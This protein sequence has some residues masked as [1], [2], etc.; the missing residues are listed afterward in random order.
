MFVCAVIDRLD[1][2]G[3]NLTDLPAA[4]FELTDLVELS[5]AGNQLTQLPHGVSR[6]VSLK[7]LVLAGNWLQHLPEQLWQL[8]GLEG[9]W[10]HGNLLQDVAQQLGSLHALRM[11]SL[12]GRQQLFQWLL[13]LMCSRKHHFPMPAV[14]SY[15]GRG[16]E[17]PSFILQGISTCV[18]WP[19]RQ[20]KNHPTL[21]LDHS[22]CCRQLP[23]QHTRFRHS[24]GTP[25]GLELVRQPDQRAAR[26]LMCVDSTDNALTARQPAAADT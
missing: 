1:L 4:L 20:V 17:V 6:L 21:S 14:F 9:L 5:L 12:A 15:E 26:W 24:A 25:A 16:A 19:H 10:V 18:I 3:C 23:W 22:T 13:L 8:T 11:L 2:S 7:K